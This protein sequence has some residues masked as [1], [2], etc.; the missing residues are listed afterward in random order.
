MDVSYAT[1]VLVVMV[2]LLTSAVLVSP[3]GSVKAVDADNICVSTSEHGHSA[4]FHRWVTSWSTI[5]VQM[6]MSTI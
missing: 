4:A 2:G 1:L 3:S 6:D 5:T